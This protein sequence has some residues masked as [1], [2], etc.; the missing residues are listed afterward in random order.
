MNRKSN[1]HDILSYLIVRFSMGGNSFSR[2]YF[3]IRDTQE[4]VNFRDRWDGYVFLDDQG[5]EYVAIV[6]FAPFQK[7][8]RKK[9]KKP[10][11]K[12]GTIEQ[13]INLCHVH[14]G[15]R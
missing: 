12:S 15:L 2:A 10:D 13:G 14:P 9:P 5:Q 1:F 7:M 11:N 6:E 4:V 8:P 3:A